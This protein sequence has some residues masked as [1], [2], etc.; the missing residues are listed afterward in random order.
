MSS[1][2]VYE[3]TAR[4]GP[5]PA[6]S[7]FLRRERESAVPGATIVLGY[8][9]DASV[10]AFTR[11]RSLG[12]VAIED[13]R[14]AESAPRLTEVAFVYGFDLD[15]MPLGSIQG[16]DF[17]PA[18]PFEYDLPDLW[19]ERMRGDRELG[20][21]IATTTRNDRSEA[22]VPGQIYSPSLEELIGS[23]DLLAARLHCQEARRFHVRSPAVEP[24]D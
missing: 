19:V 11:W 22:A 24:T 1:A 15:R 8:D 21:L 5:K 3:D 20:L 6:I 13:P 9:A 10:E 14:D 7:H 16:F 4:S 23:S 2:D 17:W 12:A 18:G